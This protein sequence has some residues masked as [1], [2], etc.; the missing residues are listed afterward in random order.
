MLGND[1]DT[2]E[3]LSDTNTDI[4]APPERRCKV[5]NSVITSKSYNG[6]CPFCIATQK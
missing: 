1:N 3:L 6:V 4:I 5:C 2:N